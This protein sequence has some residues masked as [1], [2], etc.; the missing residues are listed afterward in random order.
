MADGGMLALQWALN[1][2][3]DSVLSIGQDFI[4][5][6][7]RDDVPPIALMACE[8]FGATLPI[9]STTRT[10]V[11]LHIK[12]QANPV[13]IR[14][15]KAR[16]GYA[17]G[18][19][20][21]LLLR[22][23]A[24]ANFLALAAALVS[25]TDTFEAGSV[26]EPI[27][28]DSAA[29]TTL[30]PTAYYLQS[31]LEVL[32]PKL[33]RLGFLTEVLGWADWWT[34]IDVAF[35]SQTEN[36]VIFPSRD[37]IQKVLRAFGELERKGDLK[38][39]SIRVGRPAPWLTAFVK[40]CLGRPPIIH[41]RHGQVVLRQPGS[42]VSIICADNLPS[43]GA[44]IELHKH[45]NTF[46]ELLISNVTSYEGTETWYCTGMVP[47][48]LLTRRHLPFKSS[49]HHL[50]REAI[51]EALPYALMEVRSNCAKPRQ[52]DLFAAGI[53]IPYAV[54]NPFPDEWAVWNVATSCLDDGSVL[55]PLKALEDHESIFD[56]PLI[57]AWTSQTGS[58]QHFCR[59]VADILALSLFHDHLD[60]IQV[61]YRPSHSKPTAFSEFVKSVLESGST[62][63]YTVEAI[64]EHA[65]RLVQH[66]VVSEIRG[67]SWA[68]SSFRGQVIFPMMFE[69]KSIPTEGF[70]SLRCI[71]GTL[72]LP[73]ARSKMSVIH[74]P[75]L[76]RWSDE[77]IEEDFTAEAMNLFPGTTIKWDAYRR[78]ERSIEVRLGWTEN[79]F[80]TKPFHI[81]LAL[82]RVV[83]VESCPL[84]SQKPP[85][86]IDN[87][88]EYLSPSTRRTSPEQRPENEDLTNDVV[89]R[90]IIGVYPV[91]GNDGLRLLALSCVG[92][93]GAD[94]ADGKPSDALDD[95]VLNQYAS[96][97][98]LVKYCR[99]ISARS[100]IC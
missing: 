36:R 56:L 70:L 24:G 28:K 4:R 21:E 72:Y 19:S 97:P 100:I 95:I 77:R 86:L 33:N 40:F 43:E 53:E 32:D 64:L 78:S 30:V 51:M 68:G 50:G 34:S 73:S 57:K 91:R 44:Q 45:L 62:E 16:A 11:E 59:L 83:C 2:S 3:A 22:S 31:L 17:K 60:S 89:P 7:T 63:S 14:F 84:T 65:L 8:R 52:S 87:D 71:L 29:D 35:Q 54:C 20:V 13:L 93:D 47:P 49:Q 92:A 74:S 10:K 41:D 42:R 39:I 88:C 67:H 58:R 48:R 15:L 27:I 75:K 61:Y 98:C 6:A 69:A 82:A 94:G 9:C 26:L 66:D 76:A 1:E 37:A 99:T 38:S 46:E 81:F 96:L 5:T 85:K 80:H 90:G 23:Q 79:D 18:N 12:K 25:S 55:E